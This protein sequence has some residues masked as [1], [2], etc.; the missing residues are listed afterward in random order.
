MIILKSRAEIDKLRRSNLIASEV[1]DCLAEKVVPGVTTGELD[2]IAEDLILSKKAKPAFKGYRG[3]KHTL[4]TSVNEE[5]VHGIPSRRELKEGDIIGVD[6]GVL[7]DGFYGDIAKTFKVGKVTVDAERLL[8][9][10]EEALYV[11]I[12]KS[13]VGNRLYDISAAVQAH[14]EAAGFSV[15]RDFVGH[16]VGTSLHEDPQIPNFGEPGTGIKLRPGMVFALEP[17]VNIG[18]WKVKVLGD[19]WTVVTEDGSLSAHF[20]HTLAVTESGPVILSKR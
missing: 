17:M 12:D 14:V 18:D 11:G 4:C 7:I 13:R 10:T 15:V 16:G 6:C 1:L 8:K 5:V 19:K 3:Y 9:V 2:K 20:E